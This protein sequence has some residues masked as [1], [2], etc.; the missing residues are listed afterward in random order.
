MSGLPTARDYV[1]LHRVD[2]F[3]PACDHWRQLDLAGL[4][5]AGFGDVPLIE[6]R[7][8]CEACGAANH[9]IIVSGQGHGYPRRA[10]R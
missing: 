10:G 5:A 4:V 1:D 9:R 7:L 3:C 6:L 8:R 2:A